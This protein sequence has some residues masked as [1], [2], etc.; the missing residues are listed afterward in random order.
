M[1]GQLNSAIL[2]EWFIAPALV[3]FWLAVIWLAVWLIG[4]P[5]S[6][7]FIK[8][9]HTAVFV[10]L[11]A[12]LVAVAYEVFADRITG[13]TWIGVTMFLAEGIVLIMNGWRCPLT[14]MAEKLG[15]PHGQITDTLL[16]KWFADRVFQVYGVLFAGS[17]VVLV[18][19]LVS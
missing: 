4:L 7:A 10:V 14:A 12:L 13:V 15:S 19:R 11:S 6:I 9:A 16:P 3:L 17:L 1:F 2:Q 18:V 8:A 5:R